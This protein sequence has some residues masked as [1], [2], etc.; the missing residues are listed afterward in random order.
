MKALQELLKS[1][2]PKK[3]S[4]PK[5][6][7]TKTV[8]FLSGKANDLLDSLKSSAEKVK[9]NSERW[10]KI[11]LDSTK[12]AAESENG[13]KQMNAIASTEELIRPF[14]TAFTVFSGVK[15]E[16]DELL[17][18]T[19]NSEGSLQEILQFKLRA[20][21]TA[22]NQVFAEK[23]E[24]SIAQIQLML[25][26][27]KGALQEIFSKVMPVEKSFLP[28]KALLHKASIELHSTKL[29]KAE[30]NFKK[31]L[32]EIS[33]AMGELNQTPIRNTLNFKGTE[34]TLLE[35]YKVRNKNGEQLSEL[36][37]QLSSNLKQEAKDE[38]EIP[39]PK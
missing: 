36:L 33:M 12:I 4:S 32:D 11:L 30:S 21:V 18:L 25:P 22:K 16:V 35:L 8:K 6:E 26:T 19:S 39:L 10:N 2:S 7:P 27:L 9:S 20:K 17:A 15:N 13:L 31:E 29:V 5:K 37:K 1:V 34:S 28:L 3:K 24:T 38:K 14:A 23:L